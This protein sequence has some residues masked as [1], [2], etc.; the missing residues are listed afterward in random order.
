MTDQLTP[1]EE[2]ARAERPRRRL[3]PAGAVVAVLLFLLGFTMVVQM[4]TVAT[5]P[6]LAAARQEELVRILADLD[7]HE[8]RLRNDITEL[9]ETWRRLTTAGQSQEEALQEA[10]RRADELGILAG[11]LPVTGPGLVVEIRAGVSGLSAGA[12]LDAVQELRGA[13]AEAIQISDRQ[14]TDVRVVAGSYFLDHEQGIVVDGEL[15][16]SP[17]TITAIG[18][19]QTLQP[20]LTIPAGVVESVHSLGGT[21]TMQDEPDGVEVSAV[22]G[23]ATLR[24]ARPVS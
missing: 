21:V 23:P 12:L 8:E 13:G 24:H 6:T 3:T 4:R 10:A 11:T 18:D 20:A 14:D 22:R 16:R 5:D 19:P 15:L 1:P 2:P 17:Y 9:E 7:A